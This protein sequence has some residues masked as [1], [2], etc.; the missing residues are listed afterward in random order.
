MAHV[1]ECLFQNN[2]IHYWLSNGCP[3]EKLNLGLALY[4]RSFTLMDD[5]DPVSIGTET[6]GSG[7]GIDKR[8]EF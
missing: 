3:A 8:F 2:S 1:V 4:G 5:T 7:I 6:I